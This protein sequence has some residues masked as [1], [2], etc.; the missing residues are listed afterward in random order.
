MKPAVLCINR[1]FLPKTETNLIDFNFESIQQNAFNFIN[2]NVVDSDKENYY[3]IAKQLPQI[4]GYVVVK[5]GD[6]YLSYSRKKGAESRLHGSLSIGFGGHVDIDDFD[7]DS[8]TPYQNSLYLS[9]K[10]ELDE[11][12]NFKGNVDTSFTKAIIDLTNPVGNVHVGLP[13]TL[14]LRS[15]DQV[16][17]DPSEISEPE[18]VT[19]EQL[20]NNLELYENWSKILIEKYL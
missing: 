20:I 15:K 9:V 12:L 10:R 3:E 16:F 17:A 18:W 14:E 13:S 1:D 5:C 11:E 6:E 4:L 7:I 2:R 8:K 19:K